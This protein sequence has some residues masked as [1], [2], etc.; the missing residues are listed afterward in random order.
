MDELRGIVQGRATSIDV[1]A[2]YATFK[3]G[4]DFKVKKRSQALKAAKNKQI[5]IEKWASKKFGEKFAKGWAHMTETDTRVMLDYGFP[6]LLKQAY[7]QKIGLETQNQD[8]QN[9]AQ[10]ANES[11]IDGEIVPFD[12]I[13]FGDEFALGSVRNTIEEDVS[14][15]DFDSYVSHKKDLVKLME[16]QLSDLYEKR[17]HDKG[18]NLKEE[19]DRVRNIK[20]R[21]EE[22]ISKLTDSVDPLKDTFEI[23]E[24]DLEL[25]KHL[26]RGD[27]PPIQQLYEAEDMMSY[28][29]AAVD[30][31]G[32]NKYNRFVLDGASQI[33]N[34]LRNKL[35][36]L[37]QDFTSIND[38]IYDAKKKYLLKIIDESPTL[39]GMFPER[40]LEE[41]RD[42]L[43]DEHQGASFISA[44]FMP[45]GKQLKSKDSLLAQMIRLEVDKKR[46]E[47]KTHASRLIARLTDMTPKINKILKAK[48]QDVTW[49]ALDHR[50]F[51]GVFSNISYDVFK[52]FD[53]FGNR[54]DR[55]ISKFSANWQTALADKLHKLG[56][57][58]SEAIADND[59][60]KKNE[61]LS[62]KF[63]WL[64]DNAN[65]FDISRVP[66]IINNDLFQGWK[67]RFN[68]DEAEAYKAE[69]IAQIGVHE[70]N[71]MVEKQKDMLEDYRIEMKNII[72]D[73]FA[74][75]G[76]TSYDDLSYEGQYRVKLI[77]AVNDPFQLIDSQK[78]RQGGRV[79]VVHG[80]SSEQY[81]SQ[82]K[83]NTYFPKKEVTEFDTETESDVT[84]TGEYYDNRFDEIENDTDLYEYW[85][86]L[87]ESAEFINMN[88]A[89]GRTRLH[90]NS[91]PK[92]GKTIVDMLL[93]KTLSGSERMMI[94]R[95]STVDFIKDAFSM[96]AER[97][98]RGEE[99]NKGQLANTINAEVGSMIRVQKMKL[100]RIRPNGLDKKTN[101]LDLTQES[102]EVIQFFNDL[103]GT[104][105]AVELMQKVGTDINIHE[106]MKS[107]LTDRVMQEQTLNLPVIMRAFLD[108]SAEYRARKDAQP[109]VRLMKDL[110]H[111]IKPKKSKRQKDYDKAGVLNTVR[112]YKQLAENRL[113]G[114]DREMS[115][116]KMEDFYRRNVLAT[117]DAESWIKMTFLPKN[118]TRG[119]KELRTELKHRLDHLKE[120]IESAEDTGDTQTIMELEEARI[121][122]Q[123]ELDNMGKVYTAANFWN[124]VINRFAIYKG[125]AWNVKA[126]TINRFQGW[127]QGVIND[128]GKYWTKGNF[129]VANGFINRR[130]F[131]KI[132][133][134]STYG[135]E[136]EKVETLI[137]HFELLDATNEIDRARNASG[138]TG[139]FKKIQPFYLTE[140][141][142]WFN[143]TP[144]VLSIVMDQEITDKNG[145]TVK[146]FDGR[147]M[148][149]HKLV[150]G[151][152]ILKDEFKT[153]DNITRWEDF[154][155]PEFRD[156]QAKV[157]ATL[158]VMNGDYSKTG[159]TYAKSFILGKTVTMF[160]TWLSMQVWQ[161]FAYKQSD[162]EL[163]IKDFDGFYTGSFGSE[164]TRGIATAGSMGAIAA[165][166]LIG[167]PSGLGIGIAVG[168]GAYMVKQHYSNRTARE[169]MGEDVQY[170]RQL[171]GAVKAI[172]S[173]GM[174][175]PAKTIVN[176]IPSK[177]IRG[178]LVFPEYE[179]DD[180]N[181]SDQEKQNIHTLMNEYTVIMGLVAMK[182]MLA[183]LFTGDDEE[184]PKTVAG[185]GS[186]DNPFRKSDG[187]SD[188][189]KAY[190]NLIE[191]YT[192]RIIDDVTMYY[193]PNAF[194]NTLKVDG[195]GRLMEQTDA[196]FK[197]LMDGDGEKVNKNIRGLTMPSV[198]SGWGGFK[199]YTEREYE[200]NE[201]MDKIFRSDYKQD[202]MD[203][204]KDRKEFAD[205]MLEK[206]REETDY[207]NQSDEVQLKLDEKI[208][209]KINQYKKKL[210]RTPDR[211]LYDE[212]QKEI[213]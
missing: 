57:K 45:T 160:K 164:K 87:N 132:A 145:N 114:R 81:H 91:L 5:A 141:T 38:V 155:S 99:V 205:D 86:L 188:K 119:E 20:N 182:A 94:L 41:I 190:A 58:M 138:A 59:L 76:V 198:T 204:T 9:N 71:K 8:F 125:L 15:I 113:F 7:Q 17:K 116:T 201:L 178:K 54:T 185:R 42:E 112:K 183:A 140:A 196:L 169:E 162:L 159:T 152:L 4:P 211:R 39:K 166:T 122:I 180:L 2:D 40:E 32:Q 136:M 1:G 82:I 126:M 100:A 108:M 192:S 56:E 43:M 150:D 64:N 207:Y 14:R 134:N 168:L 175:I 29:M 143:Q 25:V 121:Q 161:R 174:T 3:W 65:F 109:T 200:N 69:I 129:V 206:L 186:R 93:D 127:Y 184:E 118:Y 62:Q 80:N 53:Q 191:N 197:A 117:S 104:S 11:V 210:F 156:M 88:I 153:Q 98:D 85:N 34:E 157:G 48:G 73:I 151:K 102:A 77:T 96:S 52:Q 50:F 13:L 72:G 28:L 187:A 135:Q 21:F 78:H 30:T 131:A 171:L 61:V 139:F 79:D 55:L 148:P 12:D 120:L 75:E 177:T 167:L 149:A 47:A 194:Y 67:S 209:N 124:A 146:V 83:Y 105:G 101:Y 133:P 189:D 16:R 173:K 176:I 36:D 111:G 35:H 193:N 68:Y 147:S 19:I 165:A 23:F 18:D 44:L 90:N 103:T 142:E 33:S 163:G 107:F 154:L 195:V 137:N 170:A 92:L 46:G 22:E 128:T 212:N 97:I 66:E 63:N 158:K 199:P 110:Y 89:D 60:D 10:Q 74:E 37:S 181:L 84:V 208:D 179:F 95:Q 70:Y 213:N 130:A 172:L 51:K 123:N 26:I 24:A 49:N 203:L 144:E 202:R 27:N 31:S 115:R 106:M 6:P